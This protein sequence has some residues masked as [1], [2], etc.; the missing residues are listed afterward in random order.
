MKS[1]LYLFQEHKKM[2][3]LS[4]IDGKVK[5]TQLAR[6]LKTYGIT[7]FLVK[8]STLKHLPIY[9]NVWNVFYNSL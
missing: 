5:Y 1:I 9:P 6:S 7:F 4:E 2:S 8:V 3:G